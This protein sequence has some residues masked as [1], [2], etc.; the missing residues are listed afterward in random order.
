MVTDSRGRTPILFGN[1]LLFL[2]RNK[3]KVIGTNLFWWW[4]TLVMQMTRHTMKSAK[5]IALKIYCQTQTFMLSLPP[6]LNNKNILVYDF[7]NGIVILCVLVAT[8][9][10]LGIVC[11]IIENQMN[12]KT[13]TEPRL[14]LLLRQSRR[15]HKLLSAFLTSAFVLAGPPFPLAFCLLSDRSENVIT[16]THKHKCPLRRKR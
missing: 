16:Q 15:Q 7:V 5:R 2:D 12:C 4:L 6:P 10:H 13:C 1:S 9:C 8:P 14:Q 3:I 11:E